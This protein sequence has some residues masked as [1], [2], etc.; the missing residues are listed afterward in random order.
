MAIKALQPIGVRGVDADRTLHRV[1]DVLDMIRGR[2]SS[3]LGTLGRGRLRGVGGSLG[4]GCV[5]VF[6]ANRPY[7]FAYFFKKSVLAHLTMPA[8]TVLFFFAK[9]GTIHR[10][11]QSKYAY[12]RKH[13][14]R[15]S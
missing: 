15:M 7:C 9:K 13:G 3:G 14:C 8:P 4:H 12:A 2:R 5:C 10:L 1:G 6:V 11:L